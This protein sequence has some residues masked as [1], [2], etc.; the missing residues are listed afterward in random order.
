MR[1][2]GGNVARHPGG[3]QEGC[4]TDRHPGGARRTELAKLP[5]TAFAGSAEY[6]ASTSRYGSSRAVD[7]TQRQDP[8]LLDTLAEVYF[9]LER[10]PD[11][12][13]TIDEAIALAP[14][15]P[16]FEQQRLRFL[17]ERA[18]D[19]RPEPPA[20]LPPLEPGPEEQP[21]DSDGP[22]VSV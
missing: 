18:A 9:Q 15:A 4:R 21:F 10:G 5:P 2:A 19:D 8:N 17:G 1:G 7:A 12:V 22:G 16:Y 13:A 14:G 3:A 11:A 6:A 20:E